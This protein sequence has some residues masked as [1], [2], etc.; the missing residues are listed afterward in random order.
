MCT[1]NAGIACLIFLA[2]DWS[3]LHAGRV[4][5]AF[6]AYDLATACWDSLSTLLH[7]GIT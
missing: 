4:Y 7:A 5:L 3:Q 1:V 6:L 2:H